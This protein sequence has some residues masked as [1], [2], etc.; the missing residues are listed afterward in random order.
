MKLWIDGK[1][2]NALNGQSLA[3][4]I[5]LAGLDA[6]SFADRPIAA[7]I[8]GEVFNLNYI[9]VRSAEE[10][11]ERNSVRRAIAASE[12]RIGLLRYSD[13]IGRDVYTRT[14]QFG[15]FLALHKLYPNVRAKMNCTVGR[16][17]FVEVMHHN[18]SAEA[19]KDELRRLVS[20]DI[21]LKRRRITTKDAAEAYASKG[22]SDK[23]R[24]LS[25]RNSDY[26]DEYYFEDFSDYYYGELA[27]S[28][29]YLSVWDI[30]PAKGGFMFL[31]PS[32]K[33]FTQIPITFL[34]S[35]KE[36]ILCIM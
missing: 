10:N 25:W 35:K 26:F 17:L 4:L 31:F 34:H 14:A 8:A 32:D 6:V 11:S 23:S 5:R 21:P 24:L 2:V 7:K 19:L 3:T 30:L 18:F 33:R 29:G 36:H 27:P 1:E 20:L 22:W 13:P 12:G 16:S 9:P 15:I 28:L